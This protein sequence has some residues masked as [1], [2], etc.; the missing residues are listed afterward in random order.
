[1]SALCGLGVDNAYVDVSAAEIPILDG[2][3]VVLG[4]K[5]WA[6][7][8]KHLGTAVLATQRTD[9]NARGSWDPACAWGE[10]GGRVYAT[11]ILCLTLQVYYRY[12]KL[13]R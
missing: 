5:A 7:W 10:D 6:E 11:A 9:G 12:G 13:A 3:A 2:S 4:G 1:M 8:Q